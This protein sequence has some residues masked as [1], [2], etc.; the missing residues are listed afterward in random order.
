[1]LPRLTDRSASTSR[2]SD[3]SSIRRALP[4]SAFRLTLQTKR[5]HSHLD[6]ISTDEVRSRTAR[7][8]QPAKDKALQRVRERVVRES[9]V[10]TP[11]I[12][13]KVVKEYILPLF[14]ADQRSSAAQGRK[15]VFNIKDAFPGLENVPGTVYSELKLS[16]QLSAQLASVHQQLQV[17][18]QSWKDAEQGKS[19]VLAD[20]LLLKAKFDSLEASL[21]GLRQ[22]LLENERKQQA[23]DLKLA[24]TDSQLTQFRDLYA[25]CDAERKALASALH[26]EKAVNDK[27][28]NRSTELEQ[29]NSLMKMEN[30]IIGERLKGLYE[31]IE[32]LTGAESFRAKLEA[33]AE[34]IG[35][36]LNRLSALTEEVRLGLYEC[37]KDRDQTRKEFLELA[38]SRLELKAD[39][40]RLAILTRDKIGVLTQELTS[41]RDQLEAF[42]TEAQKAD[43]RHKDLEEEYTKLRLKI[44]QYR[45]KRKQYGET[46]VKVCRW[47]QKEY[48]E[49]ENYNWSCRT[50][51]S[52]FGEQMYWCCGKTSKEAPGCQTRKHESKEDDDEIEPKDKEENEKMKAAS[53]RCSVIST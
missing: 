45:L 44:K 48:Y 42:R 10:I 5:S 7:G 47:C 34:Y 33:E 28:K 2:I 11:D 36:T 38:T 37:L 23:Q 9:V 21:V 53:T 20:F 8:P 19:G 17:R 6:S 27:L 18:T 43:K 40:E 3:Q 12:A 29:G 30:E 16:E 32:H 24:Q 51:T 46:E 50:H 41:A 52:E 4:T 13:A 1:M 22:H 35:Q 15:S 39:K 31:A 25:A 49:A 14:E 26:E